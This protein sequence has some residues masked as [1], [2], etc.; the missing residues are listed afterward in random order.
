L[1]GAAPVEVL[2]TQVGVAGGGHHFEDTV[3]YREQRN[4]ERAAAEVEN[5]DVL[6]ACA[7]L[8]K[9]VR[10]GRG[11]RLVDDAQNV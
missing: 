2:A 4:V 6:F 3:V 10:N 7:L 1:Y 8:I 9:A 5:E 11:G